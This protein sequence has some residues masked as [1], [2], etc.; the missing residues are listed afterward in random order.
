MKQ[1]SLQIAAG[2]TF[3]IGVA[4]SYL[5]ERYILIRLFRRDLPKIFGSDWFT[6]RTLRFTWHLTTVAW[7]GFGVLLL[8]LPSGAG[9]ASGQHVLWVVAGVF[10]V[11][12]LA[13]LVGSRGRH[14]SWVVFLAIALLAGSAALLSAEAPVT[15]TPVAE[16]MGSDPPVVAD[17]VWVAATGE[18]RSYDF[19]VGLASADTGCDQYANWWEVVGLDGILI[20]RRILTHSHISEQPF[21]RSGGP[22]TV[23]AETEVWVRAHMHIEGSSGSYSGIAFKGS[24]AAGFQAAEPVAGFGAELASQEPLPQGCAH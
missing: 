11:S 7:W 18:P 2:L 8:V 24:A 3:F 22:V 15:E 9:D 1:L 4:H 10:G 14:L 21:I 17:V 16:T 19:A 13:A 5:G 23:G 6:K 20:Y 12:G